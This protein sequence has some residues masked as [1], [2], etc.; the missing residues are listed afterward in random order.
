MN[1]F[2]AL[3]R[4]TRDVEVRRVGSGDAVTNF[5]VAI[6]NRYKKNNEVVEDTV[7]AE[8]EAWGKTAEFVG[9]YFKKGDVIRVTSSLKNHKY[10]NKEGV[11]INQS[12]F[13]VDK[14][15]FVPGTKSGVS[16]NDEVEAEV[17]IDDGDVPF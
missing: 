10:T 11:E 1:V 5:S 16:K 12:R 7:F 8:F 9:K 4:L 15:D 3:G 13:K 2:M 6:N 17:G 14:V